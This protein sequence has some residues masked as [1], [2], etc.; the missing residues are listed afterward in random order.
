MQKYDQAVIDRA[1]D[2]CDRGMSFS[3]A[4]VEVSNEFGLRVTDERVRNWFGDRERQ[5]IDINLQ[6]MTMQWFR[7]EHVRDFVVREVGTPTL[8]ELQLSAVNDRLRRRWEQWRRNRVAWLRYD[9][10]DE[11][12]TA[13]GLWTGDLGEPTFSGYQAGSNHPKV[14]VAA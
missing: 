8:V 4:A 5:N 1:I 10:V 14:E 13:L 7:T 11:V 9:S 2:L 12:V 6:P 3:L